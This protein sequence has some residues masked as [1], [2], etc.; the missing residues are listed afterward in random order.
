VRHVAIDQPTGGTHAASSHGLGLDEAVALAFALDRM[1]GRLIVHAVEAGD[2]A[3]GAGLT[4]AVAPSRPRT[5]CRCR[6]GSGRS[7]AASGSRATPVH[8]GFALTRLDPADASDILAIRGQA[9]AD[10]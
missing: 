3:Q 4:P 9:E 7:T 1:P 6:A 10:R 8:A 2:L 5:P